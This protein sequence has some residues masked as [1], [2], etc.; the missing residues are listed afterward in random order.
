MSPNMNQIT[1]KMQ[2][3]Q[4]LAMLGPAGAWEI[5]AKVFM[6]HVAAREREGMS[7]EKALQN[8]ILTLGEQCEALKL[9][10]GYFGQALAN[11]YAADLIV[12]HGGTKAA[13]AI[14]ELARRVRDQYEPKGK[15]N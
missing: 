3:A 9:E 1:A 4:S 2:L 6:K 5:A 7:K 10:H 12:H 15:V 14:E 11:A 13:D 8:S